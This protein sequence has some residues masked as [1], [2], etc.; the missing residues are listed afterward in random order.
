MKNKAFIILILPLLLV[1]TGLSRSAFTEENTL[2]VITDPFEPYIFASDS[3]IK[4]MD[5]EITEAVFKNLDIPI[6]IK[7]YPWKRCM[8]MMKNGDADAIIDLLVTEERKTYL[9]YP[10]EPVSTN[11]LVVFYRKGNRPKIETMQDLKQ[12]VVG[13]QLGWEYPKA[14]EMVLVNKEEIRSMQQ[15]F[16]KLIADRVDIM[17]ENKIVG[18]YTAKTLGL[19]GQIKILEMPKQF[20]SPYYVGFSKKKGHA[21][22]T[23]RFSEALREFKKTEEYFNI[24]KK[25]EQM[26]TER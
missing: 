15:N 2:I 12:Y 21:K 14:L 8:T 24:I 16:H 22:L 25:Y 7:Q 3:E 11:P 5:Y 19:S 1:L 10:E 6:Q 17:V 20:I 13:T 26:W 4:G 18:L 23:R 9:L